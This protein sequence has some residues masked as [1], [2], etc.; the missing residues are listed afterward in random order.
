M[1]ISLP[2]LNPLRFIPADRKL[3]PHRLTVLFGVVIAGGIAL[4]VVVSHLRHRNVQKQLQDDHAA[5]RTSLESGNETFNRGDFAGAINVYTQALG[6]AKD[7]ALRTE[8]NYR[9]CK[10][11]LNNKQ[12]NLAVECYKAVGQGNLTPQDK[13]KLKAELAL[14]IG[15]YLE[16]NKKTADARGYYDQAKDSLP[17]VDPTQVQIFI[18]C[19]QAYLNL[20]EFHLATECCTIALTPL[21]I[22]DHEISL[23]LQLGTI[24]E[25]RDNIQKAS[26]HYLRAEQ[27]P[28]SHTDLSVRVWIALSQIYRKRQELPK[29]LEYCDKAL[30]IIARPTDLLLSQ[31]HYAK[32]WILFERTK[33]LIAEQEATTALEKLKSSPTQQVDLQAQILI[34]QAHILRKKEDPSQAERMERQA[35]QLQPSE[36]VLIELHLGKALS[37]YQKNSSEVSPYDSRELQEYGEKNSTLKALYLLNQALVDLQQFKL[38]EAEQKLREA[39]TFSFD[40]PL[41]RDLLRYMIEPCKVDPA[42]SGVDTLLQ[43]IQ[44][45]LRE[46][47][48]LKTQLPRLGQEAY[49]NGDYPKAAR[50]FE[51]ALKIHPPSVDLYLPLVKVYQKLKKF[52]EADAYALR[53]LDLKPDQNIKDQLICLRAQITLGS[54]DIRTA[55][56]WFEQTLQ[57]VK[58][59]DC[60]AEIQKGLIQVHQ[61]FG[62][63]DKALEVCQAIL[64][65]SNIPKLLRV[66]IYFS[67]SVTYMLQSKIL[68]AE[69]SALN[70]LELV[71]YQDTPLKGE[72]LILISMIHAKQQKNDKALE[73][74]SDAL[75]MKIVDRETLV[76]AHLQRALC[77][78][79]KN[80][81]KTILHYPKAV[82]ACDLALKLTGTHVYQDNLLRAYILFQRAQ[83]HTNQLGSP[84]CT[85]RE[86]IKSKA[87]ADFEAALDLRS[88]DFV[89]LN[90]LLY[91]IEGLRGDPT[92]LWDPLKE[93]IE[94]GLSN[95]TSK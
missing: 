3:T 27:L 69:Q 55:K 64:N 2:S 12:I 72:L 70:G 18:E 38:L 84:A 39:I 76:A 5:A 95:L 13:A 87:K 51:A 58:D 19:S 81:D 45:K 42:L 89:T 49:N 63:F 52:G 54:D 44:Q 8:I 43:T 57:T 11:Y 59:P 7:H 20:G 88:N 30:T 36:S 22:P 94:S 48:Q 53:A 47:V 1:M 91:C 21:T 80:P 40:K 56:S 26:E 37:Y 77:L 24:E 62:H 25:M 29:A 15:H 71:R 82:N 86:E 28:A 10:A 73:E 74:V 61:R 60:K 67:K 6:M 46:T 68:E 14:E 33:L 75:K 65:D 50:I 23:R 78:G 35:L 85:N 32:A 66:E 83:C 92:K 79:Q 34:L 31:A 17:L 9:C 93:K 16:N 41:R 90:D 4:Y